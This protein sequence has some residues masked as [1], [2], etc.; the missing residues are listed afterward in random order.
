M[1]DNNMSETKQLIA[2]A[3][4]DGKI[5]NQHFG[6][7]DQF[8]IVSL[9]KSGY[10]FIETREVRPAC[11]DFQHEDHSFDAVWEVI[12]DCETVLVSKIGKPAAAYL[13]F[14]GIRVFEAS[15]L[16]SEI[17]EQIITEHFSEEEQH[18]VHINT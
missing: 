6:H 1:R 9:D 13:I 11:S 16:I 3:S 17:L 18:N 14:K 4:T 5:V 12:S 8:H 15:G 7:A 2:V 10:E